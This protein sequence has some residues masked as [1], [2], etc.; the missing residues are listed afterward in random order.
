MIPIA[1]SHSIRSAKIPTIHDQ[2]KNRAKV[3]SQIFFLLYTLKLNIWSSLMRKI[4]FTPHK[5]VCIS[6]YSFRILMQVKDKSLVFNG[7]KDIVGAVFILF[8]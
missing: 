4:K 8:I 3:G 5:I 6:I 2:K 1:L 7:E